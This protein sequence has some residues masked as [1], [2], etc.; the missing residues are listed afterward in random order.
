MAA[1]GS[2]SPIAGEQ[3]ARSSHLRPRPAGSGEPDRASATATRARLVRWL[4]VSAVAIAAA[5]V[6]GTCLIVSS[7]RNHALADSRREVRNLAFM[8]AEAS[9]RSVQAVELVQKS[10]IDRMERLGIST[11]AEY[12]DR[13]SGQDAH[14]LLKDTISGLPHVETIAIF[15]AQGEL[16]NYNRSWPPAPLNVVDRDYFKVLLADPNLISSASE[17]LRNR[18]TGTWSLYLARKFFGPGKE[19]LGVVVGG[20]EL[21]SFEDL[22][23]SLAIE[24][25]MDIALLQDD[26]TLLAQH[27]HVDSAIGTKEL[28]ARLS[29]DN[30]ATADE[31]SSRIVS[32]HG[33]ARHPAVDFSYRADRA[34]AG[35]LANRG[36]VPGRRRGPD[37]H[38]DRR[39]RLHHLAPVRQL[40]AGAQGTLRSG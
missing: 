23:G 30:T 5:I 35:G 40:C 32:V 37:G 31:N 3:S 29:E 26:G 6:L 12:R 16:V 22:F 20:L 1:M 4:I 39:D 33:L 34:D 24:K 14:L 18:T 2:H 11:A 21:K 7:L 38:H 17:P 25:G 10:L 8:L 36:L 9:D 15:D 28:R 27:P 13:M 19:L